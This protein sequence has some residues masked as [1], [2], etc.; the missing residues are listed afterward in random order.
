MATYCVGDIHGNYKALLQVIERSS[1]DPIVDTLIT[2]GDYFDGGDHI[3]C[4]E[5]IEYLIAL[6]HWIGIM[7]NHDVYLSDT[8]KNGWTEVDWHWYTIG[9]RQTLASLGIEVEV[10]GETINIRSALDPKILKFLNALQYYHID[11][12]DNVYIHAGWVDPRL[13]LKESE[14]Y[15]TQNIRDF[16][17]DRP[18]WSEASG[19][20]ANAHH[21]VFIGHTWG[22]EHPLKR[23]NIWNLDSGAGFE[24]K[25]TIMNVATEEYWQSDL[26]QELYLDWTTR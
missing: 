8:I 22:L 1:F 20:H 18:F 16:M 17:W 14:S 11:Q 3:Q 15:R 6:P 10:V 5:V 19:R 13:R 21:A 26:S 24:G 4:L 7:G 2:L 23:K 25:L 12:N 9:G